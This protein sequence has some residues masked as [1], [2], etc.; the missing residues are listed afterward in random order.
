MKC[1]KFLCCYI[2]TYDIFSTILIIVNLLG[3]EENVNYFVHDFENDIWNIFNGT[4][5]CCLFKNI[6]LK[7]IF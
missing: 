7:I 6:Y 1:L 3:M 4:K 5:I 2:Q